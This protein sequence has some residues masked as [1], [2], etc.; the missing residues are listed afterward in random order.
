MAVD[1]FPRR[2][3]SWTVKDAFAKAIGR[4][5]WRPKWAACKTSGV[6]TIR[7]MDVFSPSRR[8]DTAY[9][10]TLKGMDAKK[11]P[12]AKAKPHRMRSSA[13]NLA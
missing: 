4:R 12:F 10:P 6:V 2:A 8:N 9:A 7:A 3:A 11:R 5:S 1:D 13:S